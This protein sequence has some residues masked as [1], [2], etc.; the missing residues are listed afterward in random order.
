M[1]PT[2]Q[3]FLDYHSVILMFRR[4]VMIQIGEKIGSCLDLSQGCLVRVS[5]ALAPV[6]GVSQVSELANG[7]GAEKF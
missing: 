3:N 4:L 6:G 2:I 1:I 7:Y 5:Y